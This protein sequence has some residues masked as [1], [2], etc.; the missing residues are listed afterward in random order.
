[1]AETS[2]QQGRRVAAGRQQEQEEDLPQTGARE[3]NQMAESDLDA[4]LDDIETTLETS[5]KEYVRG[6]VQK[7]GQ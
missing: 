4:V 5:A 1:M 6:F 3:Q 2:H 7:G